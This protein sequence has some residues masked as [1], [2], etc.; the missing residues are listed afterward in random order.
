MK[1]LFL[2]K[3]VNNLS[4]LSLKVVKTLKTGFYFKFLQS[5]TPFYP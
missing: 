3:Q 4:H 5:K 1:I 2:G